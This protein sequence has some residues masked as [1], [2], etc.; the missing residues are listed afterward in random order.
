[1]LGSAALTLMGG[2]W[3]ARSFLIDGKVHFGN[4][5]EVATFA[6]TTDPEP[7]QVRA[8]V[9]RVRGNPVVREGDRC[10]F[11]IQRRRRGGDAFNCNAQVVCGGRLLFGGPDRG[12]FVCKQFDDE[13][14]DIVGDD[15]VTAGGDKDSAFHINTRDGVMKIWDDEEGVLGKF[16]VEAEI[17]SVQ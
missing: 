13:R 1:M 2:F 4:P 8:E 6:S 12:F 5:T 14:H 10:E 9:T 17:L 7:R 11:L 15:P 3:I 16:E